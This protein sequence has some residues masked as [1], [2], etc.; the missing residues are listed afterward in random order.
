MGKPFKGERLQ[1]T[2][3]NIYQSID[4]IKKYL[5]PD[6]VPVKWKEDNKTC[7]V[8]GH[9]HTASGALYML[10]GPKYLEIWR[11]PDP[12]GLHFWVVRKDTKEII[13]IT[14]AQYPDGYNYLDGNKSIMLSYNYYYNAKSVYLKVLEAKKN[15]Y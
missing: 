11:G 3:D 14:S 9:C 5:T 4:L 7:A 12:E 1:W 8:A 6:L 2:E 13:D 15:P 10:F